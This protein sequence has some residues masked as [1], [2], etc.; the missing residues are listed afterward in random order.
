M[1]CCITLEADHLIMCK[2]FFGEA[3]C[4][5]VWTADSSML[6]LVA[7]IIG[8]VLRVSL[9]KALYGGAPAL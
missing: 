7:T 1:Q 4:S 6:Y 9:T 8:C 2:S 5:S 3:T